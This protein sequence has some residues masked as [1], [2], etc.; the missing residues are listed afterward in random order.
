VRFVRLGLCLGGVLEAGRV[1]LLAVKF[2]GGTMKL[3]SRFVM[4]GSL[5]VMSLGHDLLT[6]GS[7]D[8]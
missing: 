8:P 6:F 7:G 2:S 5:S 1:I 3:G 4:L